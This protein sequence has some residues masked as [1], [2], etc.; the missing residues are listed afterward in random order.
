MEKAVWKCG[1]T[2][3]DFNERTFIMGILNVTPD[4]FSDGGT[5]NGLADAIAW[6]KKMRDEGADIID[7]G[8]ESTRTGFVETSVTLEEERRRVLPVVEVLVKDG[9]T[10]SIDTSKPEMMTEAAALGATILNDIR[11]FEMSGALEAAAAT[12]CGLV[13]MHR[14]VEPKYDNVVLDIYRYLEERTKAFEAAGVEKS[15]ICW[16]P[17]FGFGKTVEENFALIAASDIFAASG[18]PLMTAL[19]RKS[20]IGTATGAAVPRERVAGSVA[21]AL[22]GAIRGAGIVRVHDV[23]ETREALGVLK[24]VEAAERIRW[25]ALAKFRV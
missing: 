23:K 15:R 17:G 3:F 14:S 6:A 21:G 16:D 4:S 2:L 5:H 1:G 22:I 7:V 18:Q 25:D 12:D 8:G 13:V 11:G 24:A 9:F 20:S 19:S 10:V